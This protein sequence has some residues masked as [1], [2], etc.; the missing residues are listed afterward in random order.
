MPCVRKFFNIETHSSL[1]QMLIYILKIDLYIIYNIKML[2]CDLSTVQNA[3]SL[4]NL[5]N[6]II[7]LLR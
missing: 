5:Y 7:Q 4:L 3:K 1:Y 6:G 2:F